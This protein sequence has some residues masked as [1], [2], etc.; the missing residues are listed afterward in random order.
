[1]VYLRC[2]NCGKFLLNSELSAEGYCSSECAEEYRACANCGSYFQADMGYKGN[3]CCPDCAVKYKI[4]RFTD[5]ATTHRLV[6][7]LA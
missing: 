4:S 3:Y 5:T 7:E 2:R 6:K 1:M